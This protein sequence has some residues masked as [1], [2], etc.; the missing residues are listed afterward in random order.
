VPDRWKIWIDTGGTFTDCLGIDPRGTLRRVKVL[1]S[2]ALRG[3]VLRADGSAPGVL[4]IE[5]EWAAPPAGDPADAAPLFAGC[6]FRVLRP[7]HGT[8]LQSQ[9]N[10]TLLIDGVES[11]PRGPAGESGAPASV[12]RGLLRL[13]EPASEVEAGDVFELLSPEEA[14]VLAARL[15]TRT[16]QGRPLPAVDLRLATTRG[17]NA[18]LERK[19]APTVLFVTRGFGDLLVIGDQARPDLF[20]LAVEKPAP[21]YRQVVE[22]DERLAADGAVLRPLDPEDGELARRLDGL[23]EAGIDSAAVA[24]LH[25]YLR[26]EHEQALGERLERAGFT[27]VSLSSD[28]APLI[29]ILPRAETAVVDAYLAPIIGK[30]LERVLEVL[31]PAATLHVMTSAGGLVSAGEYRAKDSLLSGPAGGVVGAAEA[32]RR[33]GFPRVISFD[34]G[35]TSTDVAR[36]DGAYEYLFEHRVGDARLVAPALAIET[37]AAGGGSICRFEAG[38][39]LVGP[40]SAGASPGPACY[41]AGGPL[42]LT[43]VNL[44]LG[45]LD[46]DR[47]GIPVDRAAA[48]QRLDELVAAVESSRV[49]AGWEGDGPRSGEDEAPAAAEALLA[50]CLEIADERMADA[51]RRISLRRGYDP[52]DY[53]LVAFGGAG[54]QHACSLADLLG[55]RHVIVPADAGLL[56]AVGLGAAVVE[57][58]AQRQVLEPLESVGLRLSTLLTELAEEAHQAVRSEGI[59][60]EDVVVRRRIVYLRLAGQESTV[61]VEL[62]GCDSAGATGAADAAALGGAV[63]ER[64]AAAYST[65]YGYP[66]PARPVEVESVRVVAS[67]RPPAPAAV[68]AAGTGR[69]ASSA[70]V[71]RVLF[72]GRW[73]EAPVY[74][75]A[76]LAPGDRLAGP[77]LVFERHAATVVAPAWRAALDG[78]G[79]LVLDRVEEAAAARDPS[80]RRRL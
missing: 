53:A 29:K 51:V 34:M 10:R 32:G 73:C 80:S 75:R 35:G 79:N 66:P 39:L 58:F 2:S 8:P 68:A 67:S 64:F 38:R 1:S 24:L 70:R 52:S 7:G 36:V 71:R 62:D 65:L 23:L 4:E 76:T 43:D 54:G 15:L 77:A 45:R 31:P 56:S 22:V 12:G 61:P 50:G 9:P 49:R 57:R 42:T 69:Q 21:L 72:D 16:P 3:R 14:P 30:Y 59:P 5:A 25:S 60:A 18:L 13:S 33:S 78:A 28:L 44:L 27:H 17:T 19:G 46:P 6:R 26:P 40:E 74:D 20:A 55:I 48:E 47:F 37:V 11:L 63:A 41:G